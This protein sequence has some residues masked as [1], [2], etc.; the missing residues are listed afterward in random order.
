[1]LNNDVHFS[2]FSAMACFA[3]QFRQNAN[4]LIDMQPLLCGDVLQV[5]DTLI[6]ELTELIDRMLLGLDAITADAD[7]VHA[8]MCFTSG[9][10]RQMAKN[11]QPSVIADTLDCMIHT[12]DDS[13]TQQHTDIVRLIA[14]RHTQQVE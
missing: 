9:V 3:A 10:L 14:A 13:I 7:K 5:D 11:Y 6:A 12:V 4:M 1:L 8:T 2:A